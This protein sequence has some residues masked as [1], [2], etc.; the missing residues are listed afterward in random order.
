M[1]PRQSYTH[2]STRSP[3][4]HTLYVSATSLD[5]RKAANLQEGNHQQGGVS[6]REIL[7]N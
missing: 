4:L 3:P 6:A 7:A 2:F 5:P 1:H